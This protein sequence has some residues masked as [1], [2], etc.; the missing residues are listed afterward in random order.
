MK[1]KVLSFAVAVA[2]S[3]HASAFNATGAPNGSGADYRVNISGATATTGTMF[4]VVSNNLCD[5]ASTISVYEDGSRNWAVACTVRAA[6]G[7]DDVLFRKADLGSGFGV[8]QVDESIPVAL[9]DM[10]ACTAAGTTRT[11][12]SVTV[13]EYTCSSATVTDVPDIGISDL[14][15]ALFTGTLRAGGVDFKNITNMVVRPLS[16]LSFGVVV[17]TDLRDALQAAQGLTVGSDDEANMPS[18]TSIELRSL[19]TGAIRKWTDVGVNNG[20]T[21]Q[22]LFAV[23][24]AAGGIFVPTDDT[25]HICRRRAGSGTHAQI[26]SLILGTNCAD[27]TRVMAQATLLPFL[28]PQVS[29]TQ[30]SSDMGRC[31]DNIGTGG[32]TAYTGDNTYSGKRVWGIGYQSTE[33]NATLSEAYR[34]VKIDGYAPT[35]QNVHAGDYYDFAQSTLQ[36]RGDSTFNPSITTFGADADVISMFDEIATVLGQASQ[37]VP[38]NAASQFQH[39]W[40]QGGWLANPE[41]AGNIADD[42]LDLSNP[43]NTVVHAGNN[44][45]QAPV[46]DLGNK[47]LVD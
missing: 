43:V 44:S 8:T 17:T 42:I 12:G 14:E 10:T 38:L 29:A 11:V 7:G 34:F 18:L 13:S 47:M 24:T 4:E 31:M 2:L 41:V 26:A 21:F 30:G 3:G 39:P 1:L 9:R 36:R 40:G 46:H 25:V 32:S 27:N 19:F 23:A 37:L 35:L 15:P 28:E 33:K 20:G 16:G 22:D 45:C 6:F 5:A